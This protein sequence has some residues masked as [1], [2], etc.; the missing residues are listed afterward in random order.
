M[1]S[2]G[3]NAN[4]NSPISAV[5]LLECLSAPPWSPMGMGNANIQNGLNANSTGVPRLVNASNNMHANNPEGAYNID[6]VGMDGSDTSSSAS[7]TATQVMMSSPQHTPGINN[8]RLEC[9]MAA[10]VANSRNGS[11]N[12]G[13][14][15]ANLLGIAAQSQQIPRP[16]PHQPQHNAAMQNATATAALMAVL[17]NLGQNQGGGMPQGM[18]GGAVQQ[19]LITANMAM[20][21]QIAQQQQQTRNG[22]AN[23]LNTN[24]PAAAANAANGHNAMKREYSINPERRQRATGDEYVRLIR[25]HDLSPDKVKDIVIPVRE[26][27]QADPAFRP[28]TEQQ[29]IQQ[30]MQNK[31]FENVNI[32]ETMAQL[33]K[34]LAEKRVFGSRLMSQTTVAAPNHSTYNNLPYQ[35][36]IYIQH[37]CRNVLGPRVKSD[38]EFWD[39]F[40]EAMRK[41]AARCRRVRHAK[42]VR[43]PQ[44][45][46]QLHTN[47]PLS[48]ALNPLVVSGDEAMDI[49]TITPPLPAASTP[50]T[51]FSVASSTPTPPCTIKAE[52]EFGNDSGFKT[53]SDN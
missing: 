17:R 30:V 16:I 36:I 19:S 39:L 15:A 48:L 12:G 2:G 22:A 6:P 44:S 52:A 27:F 50:Q 18:T 38:E 35:G 33:C 11:A 10:A 43:S 25:Q 28:L 23:A 45:G 13:M 4:M 5:K 40:R 7:S 24:G 31:R 26:S 14:S 20:Q 1:M 46:Q 9:A 51:P 34:K 3:L 29:I 21:Q 32:S 8:S 49:E 42:K 47:N 53:E 41:L 37:V